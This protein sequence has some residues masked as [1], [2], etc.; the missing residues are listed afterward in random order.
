MTLRMKRLK[1][2][3]KIVENVAQTLESICNNNYL[4]IDPYV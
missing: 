1:A 2:W 3:L 4:K